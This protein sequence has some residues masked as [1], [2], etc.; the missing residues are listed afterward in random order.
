MSPDESATNLSVFEPFFDQD[1]AAGY[2]LSW[3]YSN[4]AYTSEWER[5]DN[6]SHLASFD[7]EEGGAR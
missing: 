3:P 7:V 6:K 1:L 4:P 5:F 2:R